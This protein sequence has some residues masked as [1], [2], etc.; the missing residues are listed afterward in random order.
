M[1]EERKSEPTLRR[2]VVLV[3]GDE[4]AWANA[5]DEERNAVYAQ[6]EM[7]AAALRE[8]GWSIVGGAEL[9]DSSTAKV[10][11]ADG[12]DVLVTDGPFTE[13]VEQLTGF[14]IVEAGDLDELAE[15][16]KLLVGGAHGVT[17]VRGVEIRPTG[18]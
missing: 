7:F 9:A 11:R 16:A 4:R 2:Y 17:G 14:Y 1:I 13:T 18:D 15:V 10:V 5:T 12:D 3:P 8:R 6:D